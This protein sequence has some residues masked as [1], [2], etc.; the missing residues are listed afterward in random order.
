MELRIHPKMKWEGYSSWPPSWGGANGRGDIFA[1]GEEGVL[2]SVTIREG[3]DTMP[4]H[5]ELTIEHLGSVCCSEHDCLQLATETM[6]TDRAGA[7]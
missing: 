7:V 4:I 6:V 1:G 2:R 5:L 3:D